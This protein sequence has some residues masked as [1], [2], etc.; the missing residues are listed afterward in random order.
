MY[1]SL[2]REKKIQTISLPEKVQ[3]RYFIEDEKKLLIVEAI[4][5]VWYL[6]STNNA[7]IIDEETEESIEKVQI[8]ENTIVSIMIGTE[9]AML[10][11]EEK[12]EEEAT[13]KKYL[14]A[15]DGIITIGRTKD[16]VIEYQN[17]YVSSKHAQINIIKGALIV[18]D[19]NSTNRTY[20]NN[21]R[22]N[23]QELKIGDVID[24][25]GFKIIMGKGYIAMN[26]PKN[27][28]KI[29]NHM[30]LTEYKPEKVERIEIKEQYEDVE[31]HE[32]DYFYRSPRFKREIK[33]E[34]IK[35]DPPPQ[36]DNKEK[37]PAALVAGPMVTMGL[38]TGTTALFSVINAMSNQASLTTIVPSLA[39]SGSMLA[40]TLLWPMINKKYEAK[41][42]AEKE[43]LRQE[44]YKQYLDDIRKEILN[45]SEKQ[46]EIMLENYVSL[47]E[48]KNRILNKDS[49]LWERIIGTEDFLKIR[50]GMSNLP[51][52]AEIV[53]P[54]KNFELITDNLKDE[55][56]ELVNEPKELENVP[57]TYSLVENHVSGIIGEKAVLIEYL[58]GIILQISALHSY[59]E[60]K[61]VVLYNEED[62]IKFVKWLPHIWSEDEEIRFMAKNADE[63]KEITSY[64]EKQIQI[65]MLEKEHGN[66]EIKKSAPYYVIIST[67]K[68]LTERAGFIAEILKQDENIGISL[69]SACEEMKDLPKECK[70]VTELNRDN[71]KIYDKNETNGKPLELKPDVIKNVDIEKIAIELANVKLNEKEK[72]YVLPEK[73]GFLEMFQAGKI[74]HLNILKRWKENNTALTLQTPIGI[75]EYGDIFTLDL[76][77]KYHG[78]HGLIAGM[79]GSGKSEFII[80]YI[81]SM[82]VNYHPDEV[83]FILID[84]KGGGLAGAFK[85]ENYCLPHVVGTITNLDGGAIGRSM[86]S[87]DSELKRRE[88]IFNEAKSL[89]GES[90]MDIYTYQKLYKENKVKEPLPHL[91]I[92]ADEFAELKSQQSEFMDK[93]ISIARIGRS[94]GIH[95]ILATQKPAGVV[96]D[97][98][99]SN[100]KFRVCLKVQDGTDSMEVIK[101]PDA[102]MLKQVGR[103]YLQVGYNEYFAQGQSAYCGGPYE[104]SDKI[105]QEEEKK[106]IVID[107]LG[108]HLEEAKLKKSTK[109]DLPKQIIEVIKYIEEIAKVENIKAKQLWLEP[110]AENIYVDELESKY[111]YK[112][113][114]CNEIRT[115]IGELDKPNQQSQEIFTMSLEQGNMILYGSANSGKE[116]LINTFVYGLIKKFDSDHLN[117]YLLDFG[118]ETLKIFAQAPQVGDVV[119]QYEKEKII[120]LLKMLRKEI[121]YRKKKFVEFGGDYKSYIENSGEMISN[122]IMIINN[123]EG[124]VENYQELTQELI[125]L[126]REGNKYGINMLLTSDTSNGVR[127]QLANN[128]S[129]RLVLQLNEQTDYTSILSSTGGVYPDAVK[130]RG[131]IKIGEET[132]EFQTARISKG[133]D[134]KKIQEE[135]AQMQGKRAKRIPVLPEKID[136]EFMKQYS[137]QLDRLPI[138]VNVNTL[139]I[140]N[141]NLM[142]REVTLVTSTE[143]NN[144]LQFEKGLIKLL[145][146]TTDVKVIDISENLKENSNPNYEE[147]VVELFNLMVQRNHQYKKEGKEEF[148]KVVYV[149]NSIADLINNLTL[150]GRNKLETLLEKNNK[151]YCIYIIVCDIITNVANMS[152]SNWYREQLS[153]GNGIWIGNNITQ[154]YCIKLSEYTNLNQEVKKGFGYIVENGIAKLTKFIAEE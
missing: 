51:L 2:M 45:E 99:W 68:A 101:R 70:I 28:I 67:N 150:D 90:T 59:D 58:K 97:E 115:V 14:I 43:L 102:A 15:N 122:I 119:L 147:A 92:I 73:V 47:D 143:M 23:S 128:F 129:Q 50:L 123:Y 42:S 89:T 124:F 113:E 146:E 84:Y 137:K 61:L 139:D 40:G 20:L 62:D 5:E 72:K 31:E 71:S 91:F 114:N 74:E 1:L 29:N 32:E 111:N 66:F 24:I 105:S 10:F 54:P 34:K 56:Y 110:L 7:Q 134:N 140:E 118:A 8:K 144:M 46:K 85:N 95:L 149:I 148:T 33:G 49:E 93:L 126:S 86:A 9:T 109:K 112:T 135:C 25:L 16:N 39:M 94:L 48:C 19:L 35:I 100:S 108:R 78:P 120:N 55:L 82:A 152:I 4:D 52:K 38:A 75:N 87:L 125:Y 22:V 12:T 151:K 142:D 136:I 18:S 6:K 44:K 21:Q 81:L 154:Q 145:Q 117:M 69:I 131:I 116:M 141:I 106:I 26:N 3:G 57:L 133:N 76:H 80:T 79:T 132:F 41:K 11:A 121:A 65:R 138:G 98:I 127:Y 88:E 17:Q 13:F 36:G 107:N 53:Y 104:P 63:L 30:L 60:V 103:F 64:M 27:Q 83:A 153:D 37:M 96:D 130:G 77:Q